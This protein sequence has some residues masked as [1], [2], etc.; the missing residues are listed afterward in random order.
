MFLFQTTFHNTFLPVHVTVTTCRPWTTIL[1]NYLK[2]WLVMASTGYP[3][4]KYGIGHA[5]Y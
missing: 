1:T 2:M 3:S 5:G 4:K